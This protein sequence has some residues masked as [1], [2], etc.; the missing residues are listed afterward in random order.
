[1]AP[2]L[3]AV[4]VV[5]QPFVLKSAIKKMPSAS[6]TST[7]PATHQAISLEEPTSSTIARV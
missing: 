2:D 1:M 5:A 7:D 3:T 6:P 4:P